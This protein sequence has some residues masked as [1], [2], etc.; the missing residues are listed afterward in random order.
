MPVCYDVPVMVIKRRTTCL[1]L[2]SISFNSTSCIGSMLF[3][4]VFSHGHCCGSFTVKE[5]GK[6]TFKPFLMDS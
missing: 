3:N 5:R 1:T 2:L 4:A 6:I